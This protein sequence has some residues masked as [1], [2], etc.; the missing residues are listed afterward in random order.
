MSSHLLVLAATDPWRVPSQWLLVNVATASLRPRVK[1][2][3]VFHSVCADKQGSRNA[4]HHLC[5]HALIMIAHTLDDETSN[6]VVFQSVYQ[7][8]SEMIQRATA[9]MRLRDV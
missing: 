9:L 8:N 2:C 3:E 1:R 5:L 6:R 7:G 4:L